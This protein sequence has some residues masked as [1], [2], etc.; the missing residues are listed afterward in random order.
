MLSPPTFADTLRLFQ[1]SA[2]CRISGIPL[3]IAAYELTK[4][5]IVVFAALMNS[6][7]GSLLA[8]NDVQPTRAIDFDTATYSDP[9]KSQGT[10]VQAFQAE[11]P[12]MV[13]RRQAHL[14]LR[15]VVKSV[16]QWSVDKYF[17]A[18]KEEFVSI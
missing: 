7:C 16:K 18:W 6:F 3:R 2:V 13:E 17:H 4:H 11:V 8:L 1:E 14:D 10:T 12:A 5:L 9:L 15:R